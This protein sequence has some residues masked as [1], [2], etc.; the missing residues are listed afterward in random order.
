MDS[1]LIESS[2]FLSFQNEKDKLIKEK[3][4]NSSLISIYDL[5]EVELSSALEIIKHYNG[6]SNMSGQET[7]K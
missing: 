6:F 1:Y 2:D 7:R 3:K 4:F 5:E